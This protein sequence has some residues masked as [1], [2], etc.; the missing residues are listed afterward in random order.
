V[1]VSLILSV[2]FL[3]DLLQA[4][5]VLE[6]ARHD[7]LVT[8]RHPAPLA[9]AAVFV[10]TLAGSELASPTLDMCIR[11][12]ACSIRTARQRFTVRAVLCEQQ[13]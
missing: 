12:L 3:I 13:V 10:A 9:A 1:F 5:L 2:S 11:P 8:G 6:M 7:W 4:H